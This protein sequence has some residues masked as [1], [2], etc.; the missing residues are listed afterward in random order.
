M[1]GIVAARQPI[2]QGERAE[3][4]CRDESGFRD[5][6]VGRPPSSRWRDRRPWSTALLPGT[7]TPR[8]RAAGGREVDHGA[9]RNARRRSAR[10]PVRSPSVPTPR[11]PVRICT[12]RWPERVV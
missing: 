12:K 9:Y 7:P 10:P 4:T 1:S 3:I 2:A 5:P 11:P 8:S 6:T